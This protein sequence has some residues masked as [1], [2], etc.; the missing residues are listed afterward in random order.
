MAI[1]HLSVQMQSEMNI[2]EILDDMYYPLNDFGELEPL[3]LNRN[4]SGDPNGI[5]P[6]KIIERKPDWKE[7]DEDYFYLFGE[8]DPMMNAFEEELDNEKEFLN[9]L[10]DFNQESEEKVP[11]CLEILK[12]KRE[13]EHQILLID[14]L[15]GFFIDHEKDV[16]EFEAI[17]REKYKIE[18][19]E[20]FKEVPFFDIHEFEPFHIS[21][22]IC[23]A[24]T[25]DYYKLDCEHS[26]C[27]NCITLY[28][29]SLLDACKIFEEDLQCPECSKCVNEKHFIRHLRHEDSIRIKELREKFKMQKL[30]SEK[31]AI[32]CP[33]PDC[34]GYAHLIPDE[35]ITACNKCKC[36]L[37]TACGLDVHPNITCEENLNARDDALDRLL[38]SQNWKKCPTCGVPVEKMSGCQFLYCTSPICKGN[39]HLCF[40][41]GKF[42]TEAL[43]H[44]HYKT[45]GPYGDS[46]NTLDGIPEDVKIE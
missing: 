29:Y 22:K 27:T 23:F 35:K 41:C 5:S 32:A 36:S 18:L 43:H 15:S 26:Y 45:K 2:M 21:C 25:P 1:F 40:L 8:I 30:I 3:E 24:L 20:G 12:A 9:F 33:V 37:C 17:M 16:P 10:A 14:F 46:C 31:K 39:K 19:V 42:L 11:T 6:K 13:V 28:F 38:L 7:E 4:L 44:A 34:P